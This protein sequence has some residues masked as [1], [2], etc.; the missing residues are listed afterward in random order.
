MSDW[1]F[2][3]P[4]TDYHLGDFLIPLGAGEGAVTNLDVPLGEAMFEGKLPQVQVLTPGISD[5]PLYVPLQVPMGGGVYRSQLQTIPLWPV[6]STRTSAAT[7]NVDLMIPLGVAMFTGQI[8]VLPID[9]P[10]PRGEF[11]M[12]GQV[13]QVA[14]NIFVPLGEA[15]FIGQIP[16]LT[17]S[18]FWT[19]ESTA[20]TS[21]VA[22]PRAPTRLTGS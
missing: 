4:W 2:R 22:E 8:P 1:V 17:I 19:A 16:E 7:A 11:T 18:K 6:V 20:T 15:A 10:L 21:W 3:Q 9:L 5:I 13:H 12:V 14:P